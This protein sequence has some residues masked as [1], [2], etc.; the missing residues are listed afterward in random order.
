[1]LIFSHSNVFANFAPSLSTLVTEGISIALVLIASVL[2]WWAATMPRDA[3]KE[4]LSN[5]IVRA[6]GLKAGGQE[7]GKN[8]LP[9]EKLEELLR[10]VEGLEEGAF[11]PVLQQP[12]FRGV[13]LPLGSL[14]WAALVEKG[15]IPGL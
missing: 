12:L 6:K 5:E 13:L 11:S 15:I 3:L 7:E 4:K 10:Q 2:L 1:M 14:G 9:V 8:F